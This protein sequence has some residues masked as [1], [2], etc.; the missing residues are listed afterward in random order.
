MDNLPSGV[1]ISGYAL[2]YANERRF[3]WQ[4]SG[5]EPVVNLSNPRPCC[6]GFP[7]ARDAIQYVFA[8]SHSPSLTQQQDGGATGSFFNEAQCDL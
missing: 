2:R 5:Y 1:F 8:G 7:A 3:E 4:E 6:S